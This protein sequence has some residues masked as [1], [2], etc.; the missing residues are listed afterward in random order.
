VKCQSNLEIAGPLRNLSLLGISFNAFALRYNN[1]GM[2]EGD[3]GQ[4]MIRLTAKRDKPRLQ[5]KAL[6]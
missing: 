4:L 5:A 3:V 2:L 1:N 6:N